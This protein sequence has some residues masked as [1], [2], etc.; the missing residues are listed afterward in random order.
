MANQGLG[1]TTGS[2]SLRAVQLRKK[3]DRYI[4]TRVF[5]DRLDERRLFGGAEVAGVEQDRDVGRI[6]PGLFDPRKQVPIH[7]Q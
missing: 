1:V 7:R 6:H 2:H 5:A 3:G 4:V